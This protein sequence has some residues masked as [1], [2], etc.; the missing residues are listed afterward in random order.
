MHIAIHL[1]LKVFTTSIMPSDKIIPLSIKVAF[2]R[3]L[4]F[5]GITRVLSNSDWVPFN[6]ANPL[7]N[8]SFTSYIPSATWGAIKRL[9][10]PSSS[11]EVLANSSREEVILQH[12]YNKK[13][14]NRKLYWLQTFWKFLYQ[15][16]VNYHIHCDNDKYIQYAL[17]N[18]M[19]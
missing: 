9:A 15:I 8:A 3:S 18:G 7:G 6:T 12:T 1:H 14:Y 5:I 19:W 11:F 17:Q 10:L 16:M 13:Y 4:S 2:S